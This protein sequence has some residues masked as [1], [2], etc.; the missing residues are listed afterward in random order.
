MT[1]TFQLNGL[2]YRTDAE[3]LKVLR[4]VMPGAKKS[5]DS[6]AVQFIIFAGTKT[7]RIV[8]TA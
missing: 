3:T 2:S 8:Q 5:G 7:G 4:S 6:T 1:K